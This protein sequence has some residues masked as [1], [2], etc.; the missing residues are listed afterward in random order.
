MSRDRA[1]SSVSFAK[2]IGLVEDEELE[3]RRSELAEGD[4][5]GE[6]AEGA[7]DDLGLG[8]QLDGLSLEG[9]AAEEDYRPEAQSGG[10]REA[11]GLASDLDGELLRRRR[12]DDSG[13]SDSPSLEHRDELEGGRQV[14]EGLA[15]AGLGLHDRVSAR[16]DHRDGLGLHG[17]RGR[18][19]ERVQGGREG[20]GEAEAREAFHPG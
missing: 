20:L 2:R 3:G 9:G 11:L 5:V 8:F 16:K 6:P 18:E 14:G 12:D 1:S 15:R 13:L 7:H 17:R 19:A 4:E 10:L